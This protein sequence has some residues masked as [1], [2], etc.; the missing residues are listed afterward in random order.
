MSQKNYAHLLTHCDLPNSFTTTEP[1]T[2]V[3]GC[4]QDG[5]IFLSFD[6]MIILYPSA[7]IALYVTIKLGKERRG[8]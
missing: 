5:K 8:D 2:H 7:S 4:I 6:F 1:R 3:T